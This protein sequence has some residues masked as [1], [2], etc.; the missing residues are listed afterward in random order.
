MLQLRFKRNGFLIC[1]ALAVVLDKVKVVEEGF[2]KQVEVHCLRGDAGAFAIECLLSVIL[3]TEQIVLN[4]AHLH[5]FF[6]Y[7]EGEVLHH[8][9]IQDVL[10][11]DEAP[12]SE[13]KSS[14]GIF[15]PP[16]HVL[17][18]LSQL[19]LDTFCP[20]VIAYPEQLMGHGSRAV[21]F[22]SVCLEFCSLDCT[23]CFLVPNRSSFEKNYF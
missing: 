20:M 8:F 2:F 1:L 12:A 10:F 13:V 17:E 18:G 9:G 19:C 11:E 16:K 6:F 15:W 4:E 14:I 21:S 7:S 3:V 22:L 5:V 23:S